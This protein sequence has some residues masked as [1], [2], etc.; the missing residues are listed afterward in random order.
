LEF[1]QS[2]YSLFVSTGNIKIQSSRML[3]NIHWNKNKPKPYSSM[4][5]PN[6]LPYFL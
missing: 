3:T 5:L 2:L 4:T 6:P 1:C